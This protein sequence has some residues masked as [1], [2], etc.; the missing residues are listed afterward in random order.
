MRRLHSG[1]HIS[2]V[3]RLAYLILA[4]FLL[5]YGTI[6]LIND[7]LYIPGK[8]G[9]AVFHGIPLIILYSSMLC[10]ATYCVLKIVRHYD[11]KENEM[12]YGRFAKLASFLGFGL[13]IA[14]LLLETFVFQN[15]TNP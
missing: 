8:F 10:F 13:F 2:T 12:D 7:G 14:A 9:G 5:V 11:K 3:E 6:S 4:S 15:S 1:K